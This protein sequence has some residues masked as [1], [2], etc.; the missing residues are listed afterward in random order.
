MRKNYLMLAACFLI[1]SLSHSQNATYTIEFI[2]NWGSSSHP[3]DFPSNAHWSS[4]IG[5]SHKDVGPILQLGVTASDGV[6]Q[7]AETGATTII[8]QEINLLIAGGLAN[9]II[10]GPGLGSGLGTI[11][12]NTV[13][14][15]PDFPYVSLLT[16]VAPSPDWLAQISNV[17]LTDASDE[18]LP[19]ISIDVHATDAGTDSGITYA[20]LNSDTVPA[21]PISSLENTPPFSSAIVGTFVLTLE[22]VLAVDD[23]FGSQA[24][25]VYPN[26][27]K[28]QIIIE[29]K[30]R[31]TVQDA[32]LY[33]LR[34]KKLKTFGPLAQNEALDLSSFQAG[35]YFLRLSSQSGVFTKKLILK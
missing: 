7:V 10:S 27:A 32:A 15:D 33:S 12:I 3:E 11:T 25:K 26:P 24:I 23:D 6:E 22:A 13:E 5:A 16:M 8:T 34:G 30:S 20:S 17:K 9:S 4:L 28:G 29:N 2:S 1:G 35:V 31:E 21:D 14:F 18:W 19:L